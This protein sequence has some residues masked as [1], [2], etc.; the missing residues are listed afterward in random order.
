VTPA[1][2]PYPTNAQPSTLEEASASQRGQHGEV[3]RVNN[4][5]F[6]SAYP[7]SSNQQ[8]YADKYTWHQPYKGEGILREYLTTGQHHHVEHHQHFQNVAPEQHVQHVVQ[9]QQ[10]IH[11]AQLSPPCQP[12]T[13]HTLVERPPPEPESGPQWLEP[14]EF[15]P[16]WPP[17]PIQIEPTTTSSPNVANATVTQMHYN[18]QAATVEENLCPLD[19]LE[20]LLP[21][22]ELQTLEAQQ[23]GHTDSHQG[24]TVVEAT[25]YVNEQALPTLQEADLAFLAPPQEIASA[26]AS[27][28]EASV[29]A[30]LVEEDYE[31]PE[32]LAVMPL[33]PTA[34]VAPSQHLRESHGVAVE[35]SETLF[36]E[37]GLEFEPDQPLEPEWRAEPIRC[38]SATI[39]EAAF[40]V[41][42]GVDMEEPVEASTSQEDLTLKLATVTSLPPTLMEEEVSL[43][44]AA[45]VTTMTLDDEE[46]MSAPLVRAEVSEVA[47]M[48]N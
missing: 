11:H 6:Y 35:E 19:Q 43:E 4:E 48:T 3:S 34:I 40:V 29:V 15:Y 14:N 44:A 10:H 8:F 47:M 38:H 9:Q 46:E 30:C 5:A 21:F 31:C 12:P 25:S 39:E 1:N 26:V 18:A 28:Q 16:Q 45:T 20:E 7:S 33:S 22:E 36:V 13:F 32:S 24:L 17:E 23:I 27:F 41:E 37:E 2:S 42:S